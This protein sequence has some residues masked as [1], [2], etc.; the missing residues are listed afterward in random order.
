MPDE[1]YKVESG[2]YAMCR[3][4]LMIAQND[5]Y[6]PDDKISKIE[7]FCEEFVQS[8]NKRHTDEKE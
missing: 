1:T 4:I 6:P 8:Y 7:K 2:A 3:V 5:A